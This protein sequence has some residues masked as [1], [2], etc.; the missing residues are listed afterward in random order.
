M[1]AWGC[2]LGWT[3]TVAAKLK[4]RVKVFLLA[5]IRFKLNYFR[6]LILK[7]VC[8]SVWAIAECLVLPL[9]HSFSLSFPL[10]VFLVVLSPS[11]PF[12]AATELSLFDVCLQLF[13]SHF[14]PIFFCSSYAIS[15]TLCNT[16]THTQPYPRCVC[17][18]VWVSR[19][20]MK[21]IWSTLDA[22]TARSA[23]LDVL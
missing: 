13:S 9:S 1:A 23:F 4:F 3:K 18:C 8:V 11:P 12:L 7:W 5:F 20:A 6:Q 2:S 15:F 22:R 21:C 17:V 16:H 14:L 19:E 10:C